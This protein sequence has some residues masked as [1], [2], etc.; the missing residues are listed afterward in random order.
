MRNKE[1]K[2][3]DKII[4]ELENEIKIFKEKRGEVISRIIRGD[5]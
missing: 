3:L 1:I 4:D 5:I 2:E